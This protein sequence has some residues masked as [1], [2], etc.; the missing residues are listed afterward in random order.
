[1][2]TIAPPTRNYEKRHQRRDE[3]RVKLLE[4]TVDCLNELGFHRLTT[5]EVCRRAGVS[6][7]TF[8]YHFASKEGVMVAI[9]AYVHERLLIDTETYYLSLADLSP[10]ERISKLLDYIWEKD[11]S[12][13]YNIAL[14]EVAMAARSDH[15]LHERLTPEA[16]ENI[17]TINERWHRYFYSQSPDLTLE[18]IKDMVYIFVAG[19]APSI[20]NRDHDYQKSVFEAW[21]KMIVPLIG[22]K[23]R[24]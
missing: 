21:K 15:E 8:F 5:P 22:V 14:K 16:E 17:A 7:G 10:A 1:M 23:E 24:T 11:Y 3:T 12:G 9:N 19:I 18:T 6:Q 13:R 20:G 2:D 4:A